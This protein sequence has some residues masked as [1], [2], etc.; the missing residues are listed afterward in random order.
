MEEFIK[1]A[2]R[3]NT[4]CKKTC[5]YIYVTMIW[6]NKWFREAAVCKIRQENVAREREKW[7]RAARRYRRVDPGGCYDVRSNTIFP[8]RRAEALETG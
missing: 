5:T 7:K 4:V 3:H 6:N 8:I 1:R 2:Q